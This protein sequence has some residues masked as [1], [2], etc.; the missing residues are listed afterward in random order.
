MQ[1]LNNA[2]KD[3]PV[4]GSNSAIATG[5]TSQH[6]RASAFSSSSSSQLH[7]VRRAA[8][9]KSSTVG[10]GFSCEYSRR[11]D[12]L[13]RRWE[14][15]QVDTALHQLRG[16]AAGSS[17]QPPTLAM[18][19]G[20]ERERESHGT[21]QTGR[22]HCARSDIARWGGRAGGRAGE[23][24]CWGGLGRGARSIETVLPPARARF[25]SAPLRGC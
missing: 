11:H 24:G 6:I 7:A 19:K 14:E 13:R 5:P 20:R 23:G 2:I 4:V 21:T 18:H 8:L 25:A 9:F 22:I 3:D 16:K 17:S 15:H 10:C 1:W 12:R